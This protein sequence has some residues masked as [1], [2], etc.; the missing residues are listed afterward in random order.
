MTVRYFYE[1]KT[2]KSGGRKGKEYVN[3]RSV[4]TGKTIKTVSSKTK[5]SSAHKAAKQQVTRSE[6]KEIDQELRRIADE[7]DG[8]YNQLKIRYK[9]G[10][11]AEKKKEKQRRKQSKKEGK[12]VYGRKLSTLKKSVTK[13]L[14]KTSGYVTTWRLFWVTQIAKDSPYIEAQG[15]GADKGDQF[16]YAVD[17]VKDYSLPI[18]ARDK[19]D[20]DYK[21]VSGSGSGACVRLIDRYTQKTVK[22]FG[23]GVGCKRV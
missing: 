5:V 14:D 2:F 22:S 3:I 10:L 4:K 17:M 21:I 19:Q 16:K 23:L 13:D 1:F 8:N 20:Y 12:Q 18:I 7:H 11:D 15:A 6:A 9:S